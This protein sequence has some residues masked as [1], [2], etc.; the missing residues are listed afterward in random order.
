M[1]YLIILYYNYYQSVVNILSLI[2]IEIF[3][4]KY[5]KW[6]NKIQALQRFIGENKK[7]TQT[8]TEEFR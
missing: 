2:V 3:C 7:N 6:I 8:K 1:L 4:A 5:E